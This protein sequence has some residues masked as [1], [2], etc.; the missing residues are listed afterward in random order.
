MRIISGH[1]KGLTIQ[2]PQTGATRPTSDRV[3]ETLFNII[4]HH[5]DCVSF[6]GAS[7]LDCFAGSGALGFE[8]LSR[9]ASSAFFVEENHHALNAIRSNSAPF[10]ANKKITVFAKDIFSLSSFEHPFDIIFLDPPYYKN[11][12]VKALE[13]LLKCASFY[14]KSFI[15]VETAHDEILDLSDAFML[16]SVRKCGPAKLHFLKLNDA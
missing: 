15:V 11:L 1:F 13:H 16:L 8:A 7:I 10:L 2:A 12:V 9:G 5:P 3:R 14:E 4:M 6:D